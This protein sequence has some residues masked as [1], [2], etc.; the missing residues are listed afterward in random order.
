MLNRNFG[1][2]Q[3]GQETMIDR[4]M[5]SSDKLPSDSAQVMLS[6]AYDTTYGIYDHYNT[7]DTNPLTTVTMHPAED[8][9]ELS[10]MYRAI[11]RYERQGINNRFG[12]SLTEYLELPRS[13]IAMLTDITIAIDKE[14][15]ALENQA[16]TG[17]RHDVRNRT[18]WKHFQK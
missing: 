1:Y 7:S 8:Y 12:L 2:D 10:G 14:M 15:S 4:L 17:A 18:S 3:V 5:N 13:V 6:M 9:K 16:E 11:E